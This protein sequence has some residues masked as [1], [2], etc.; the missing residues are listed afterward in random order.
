M[1]DFRSVYQSKLTT[2]EAAVERIASGVNLSMGMAM[3]EPPALLKALADRAAA[4]NVDG[5]KLYY[6]ESTRIAA[7]TVLRYELTERIHPYCMFLSPVERALI[8]RGEQDGGRKILTYVPTNFSQS[9]KILTEH[10]GVDTFL[11]TVSPMD[12]HGYFTFGTGNDYSTKVA[13]AA[14]HLIVEVND[15]MPRV[16]G[17]MPQLHV[18]EVEAIV[19]NNVPLLELPVRASV[20]EDAAIGKIVAEMVPD[21]ACLQM[22]VGALPDLVCS[23]LRGRKDL[24]IHTEALCPGM[25]ELIEGGVVTNRRK[26]L[27]PG[28]TVFTFAMG[29][30]AMYD[31][32]DDNPSVESHPVDYVNN[33]YIISQ[34]DNVISVNAALQIDLTGAVNAEHMLGHQYSATGGQLDFVRGAYAS[35]G[36]K[37]IIACHSTAA[38][39]RVS[40]IVP[41]LDGPVT[42]P[43]IDT[44]I[45]VTEFGWTNLKGKSSTERAY[46]LIGLADPAFRDK[47]TADAKLMHII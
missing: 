42:T 4:G 13:R 17:S 22:G 11:V 3:T 37:S 23:Y 27:N 35:R 12:E 1:M 38:K 44:H 28:K 15:Q 19:E 31:F 47:L 9:S 16:Y 5:L 46:A 30:K 2:P 20:P 40:R 41:R 32:L 6:F 8:K 14:K 26:R 18:S 7:E 43:R 39:G 25:I 21:G 29:Q 24:G 36:G 45:V 10:I 33:P 34:N